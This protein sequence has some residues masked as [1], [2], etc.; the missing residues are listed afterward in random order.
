MLTLKK[1]SSFVAALSMTEA[2]WDLLFPTGAETV[3]SQIKTG[4]PVKLPLTVT[5]HPSVFSLVFTA[6]TDDWGLGL[7][8]FDAK[9]D[10]SGVKSYIPELDTFEFLLIEGVT[11]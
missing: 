2:E 11:E 7:C 6:A 4:S 10:R 8:K 3:T 9:I 5:K 1:S